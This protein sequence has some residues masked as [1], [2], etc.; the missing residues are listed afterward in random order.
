MVPGQLPPSSVSTGQST[1]HA[2]G[3]VE[4]GMVN[5]AFASVLM[6]FVLM[7]VRR[8]AVIWPVFVVLVLMLVLQ[9]TTH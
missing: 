3:H 5:M 6:V 4:L 2:T 9:S 8:G 1:G 7:M